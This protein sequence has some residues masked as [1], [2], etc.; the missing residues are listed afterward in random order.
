MDLSPLTTGTTTLTDPAGLFCPDQANPGAFGRFSPRTITETGV[1]LGGLAS[2]FATTVA[3]V[4]CIPATGSPLVN[5]LADPPG[6][7]AV[8][9]SGMTSIQLF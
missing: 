1:P 3:G 5:A 9:V 7:A 6:P 2:P 8:S 4:F